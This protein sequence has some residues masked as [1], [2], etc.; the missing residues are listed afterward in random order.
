MR[1][2][3]S[4]QYLAGVLDSDGSITITKRH[5]KRLNPNYA[6]MIQITWLYNEN[7]LKVFEQIKNKYGGSYFIGK[8]H[9]GFNNPKTIIK[10]C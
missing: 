3:I 8:S 10:Y 1:T 6:A 7:S 9:S 2:D 4:P 5:S